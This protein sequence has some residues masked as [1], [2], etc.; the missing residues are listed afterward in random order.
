MLSL[1]PICKSAKIRDK[2]A[3]S[4]LRLGVM[5]AKIRPYVWVD[6]TTIPRIVVDTKFLE[7]FI[8]FC[9]TLDTKGMSDTEHLLFLNKM[10]TET[11]LSILETER[12]KVFD[13]LSKEILAIVKKVERTD[14]V[15]TEEWRM[16]SKINLERLNIC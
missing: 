5:T 3:R 10:S 4:I 9:A 13:N 12:E 14:K 8:H 11:E 7:R 2:T 6:E 15:I 1:N 16:D